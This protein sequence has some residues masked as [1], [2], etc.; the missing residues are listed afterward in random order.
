MR[1]RA[2]A[3]AG[4]FQ[5]AYLVQQVARRGMTDSADFTTCINSLY[6]I[7]ATNSEEIFGSA[8]ALRTG[9]RQAV[10]QLSGSNGQKNME[11][12]R[13][14]LGIMHLERKLA[15]DGAMLK[16]ISTG[17]ERAKEQ[18]AMF[19][20]TH[21]NVIASLANLYV[22]TISTLSPRIIVSGEQG[23]IGNAQNADK[24]RTLLLAAIRAAVL[25]RQCGGRR[26][27]LLFKRREVMSGIQRLFDESS[28]TI[29]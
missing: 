23:H 15:K 25:W 14:A 1:D 12:T 9:L 27:H 19:G 16:K 26:W 5:A 13:Y 4:I 22:E 20:P 17:I 29:H 3:L 10:D 2:I 18:S 6:K 7:D 28:Q 8:S 24:I 21:E 11:V